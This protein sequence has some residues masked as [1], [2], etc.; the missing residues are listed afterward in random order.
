[1]VFMEI[2]IVNI[3]IDFN[4]VAILLKKLVKTVFFAVVYNSMCTLLVG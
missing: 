4:F 1:M 3:M 2:V